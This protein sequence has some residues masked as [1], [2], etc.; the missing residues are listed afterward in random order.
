MRLEYLVLE[1]FEN[2]SEHT[3]KRYF[4]GIQG[5]DSTEE[6]YKVDSQPPN[7]NDKGAGDTDRFLVLPEQSG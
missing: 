1:S 3:Q 6:E 7:D 2:A 5:S 4:K